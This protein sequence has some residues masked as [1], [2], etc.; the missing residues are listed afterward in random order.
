[1]AK[2]YF[3]TLKLMQRLRDEVK[4][5]QEQAEKLTSILADAFGEW[6]EQMHP[7]AKPDLNGNLKGG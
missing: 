7:P 2:V 1:M 4:V 6:Q 5:P 3:D